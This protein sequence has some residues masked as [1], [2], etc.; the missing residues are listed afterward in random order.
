MFN[1]QDK[2]AQLQKG[3][4]SAV[5]QRTQ[6]TDKVA[7]EARTHLTTAETTAFETLTTLI[8]GIDEEIEELE[9]DRVRSGMDNPEVQ[10]IARGTTAHRSDGW[11]NRAARSLRKMSGEQRA[12]ASGSVD[13]PALVTPTVTPKTR[14]ERLI[15]LLVNRQAVSGNAIEYFRQTVRTNNATAVADLADKPTSVHTVAPITD[16][17][18]VIAHLS[19]AVPVRLWQD[20]ADVVTWLESEMTEGVLDALEAQVIA[21]DGIGEDMTGLLTVAGT[22]SV[23]FSTSVPV[24]LRKAVTALQNIGVRP[25]AWVLNPSDVEAL[26]LLRYSIDPETDSPQSWLLDGYTNG[27]TNS[28][29]I[30]GDDSVARVISPS[31]PAGTAVLG[32]WSQIRLYVRE[33]MRLDVDAGGELFTKNAAVLR[34]EMRAVAAHLRPASF[35]KVDIEP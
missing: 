24:T 29:N 2:I 32:D 21:G 7:A 1:Y 35:A 3:R 17:C 18:R 12:I 19:E 10:R 15:D 27:I 25:N 13:V 33:D 8:R 23:A 5:A 4:R 6:I 34:A 30:F 11:A 28:G 16:R 14:P 9:A 22:T 31:V 26:D 20:A